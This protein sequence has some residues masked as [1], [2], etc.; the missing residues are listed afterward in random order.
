VRALCA[1]GSLADPLTMFVNLHPADLEDAD[2]VDASAPLTAVASRVVLEVTERASIVSTDRLT[3]RLARLR[4]LGFRLA[5]DDI[6]A[7]YSGLQSF[8][9]LQPEFVKIDMALVRNV[10]QSALKQRTIAALCSLC[11]EIGCA[12][13]G[14]GVETQD[15][16]ATLVNLGCD[17]IQGYLI[18]RP[19]VQ[20]PR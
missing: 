6:G 9:D 10:H 18:A 16:R 15:E 13:V 11:H 20:L 3:R 14:E 1:A 8:T 5:V 2:L 12:V 19:S 4:E 7:G 17:L